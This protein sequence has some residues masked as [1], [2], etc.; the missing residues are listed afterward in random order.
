M[1]HASD[2]G[3]VGGEQRFGEHVVWTEEPDVL[4]MRFGPHLD[5]PELRAMLAYQMRW[6]EDKP[7]AFVLTD[8]SAMRLFTPA[9]RSV[10]NEMARSDPRVIN[11]CY[12]ASFTVRVIAEMVE[13]ARRLL[14]QGPSPALPTQ[15][16]A[17]EADAR[18]LVTQMRASA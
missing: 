13:R 1:S 3:Q 10:T 17:T 6:A 9:A 11:I 12:G 8:L 5:G 2:R 15:F 4:V 18:E 14:G 16:L 7:R